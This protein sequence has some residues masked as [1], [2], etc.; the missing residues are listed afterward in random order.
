MSYRLAEVAAA[1]S[2]NK[3]TVRRAIKIGKVSATKDAHGQWHIEP[4]ELIGCIHRV[5]RRAPRSGF[6]LGSDPVKFA[7]VA[8][9]NRPGGNITGVTL[10][11]YLLNAKRR[12]QSVLRERARC[13]HPPCSHAPFGLCAPI[14][15][16]EFRA[17]GI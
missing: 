3:S 9:L 4:A 16:V 6:T 2:L 12:R 13:E 7:L 17:L 15:T 1:C 14:E 8:S 11:A 10:F 5:L